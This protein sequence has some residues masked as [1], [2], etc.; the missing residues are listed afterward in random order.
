L[1]TQGHDI[2]LFASGDSVTK[3]RLTAT[4]P[5]S[6]R[7][8]P[9]CV[10]QQAPHFVMLEE[11]LRRSEEFDLIHF[12]VDYMHYPFSRRMKCPHL[13]TLHGRL[14]IPEL[15]AIYKEYKEMPVVSISNSQRKPLPFANWQG[16]VYHGLP[17]NLFAFGDYPDDNLVFI[18]RT[19][20]EKRPDRAIAIAKKAK[21]KIK[22]AA[23]VDTADA[24]YFKKQIEPL[25][26]EPNVQFL[27]ERGGREKQELLRRADAFLFPID[28]PE[29]FGL[30]I[31]EAMACGTP[32]I[33]WKHGSVPELIEDGVT[34]FT[35]ESMEQAVEAV[36]R[37]GTLSRKR[38]RE[39]F[40]QRFTASRMARDYLKIYERL[41][42]KS[43]SR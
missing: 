11:V 32:V 23:K 36:K 26:K 1:V 13:T 38:C 9:N 10:D 27:G 37:V 21:R 29:P 22:I 35:V 40:V 41:I 30:V 42:N 34:G 18:G 39:A 43:G 6:L 4:C 31:I 7:T 16:T 8:N 19:S 33:A 24:E 14:D 17:E 5:R 20:K 12:H 15:Q 28:W 25:L 3:A 2:T